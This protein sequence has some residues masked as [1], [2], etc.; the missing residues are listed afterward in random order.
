MAT[1]F[2]PVLGAAFAEG[3]VFDVDAVFFTEAG[4]A[5]VV[6]MRIFHISKFVYTGYQTKALLC[7]TPLPAHVSRQLT[8]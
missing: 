7:C 4:F 2:A 8:A 6:V 5:G 3:A 1:F